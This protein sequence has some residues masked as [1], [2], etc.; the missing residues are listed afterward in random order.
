M[1][2]VLTKQHDLCSCPL[3]TYNYSRKTSSVVYL[4]S[5]RCL[6]YHNLSPNFR[7][8]KSFNRPLVHI[9][10][11]SFCTTRSHSFCTTRITAFVTE[12]RLRRL[13]T[14][15]TIF[16]DGSFSMAPAQFSQVYVICIPFRD[17]VMTCVY[18]LLQN[19]SRSIY[20]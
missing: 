5:V 8:Q 3:L 2:L 16:M 14:A 15:S 10:S 20:D 13:A 12:V 19:K 6:L 9:G 11:H 1:H 7:Y 4:T 17:V 18:A